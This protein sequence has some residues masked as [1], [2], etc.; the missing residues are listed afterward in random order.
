MLFVS[1]SLKS[2]LL[3]GG[4]NPSASGLTGYIYLLVSAVPLITLVVPLLVW[5]GRKFSFI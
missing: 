3:L 5:C 1:V 4:S 2:L